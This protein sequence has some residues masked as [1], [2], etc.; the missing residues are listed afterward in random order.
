M[1][2]ERG[3]CLYLQSIIS[4]RRPAFSYEY[5]GGAYI[6]VSF[7]KMSN[8]FCVLHSGNRTCTWFEISILIYNVFSFH[9]VQS[10]VPY[11]KFHILGQC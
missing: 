7:E 1:Y 9:P 5:H 11:I 4:K 10:L 8:S 2:I 3:F 6:E